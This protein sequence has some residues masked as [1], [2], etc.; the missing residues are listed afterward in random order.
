METDMLKR[1]LCGV[2]DRIERAACRTG[3]RVTL[4]AA[5][6]TVPAETV[7]ALI[8]MGVKDVGENR[9]QEYLKKRDEVTGAHWH[10]IGTLQRNKAK[11]LVGNVVLIQSVSSISLAEE[12]DRLAAERGVIQ[13]V[14]AELNAADEPMKTGAK[15]YEIDEL[16]ERMRE[17]THIRLRGLMA[18]PPIGA[19]DDVYRRVSR[20]YEKYRSGEFDTLS[21]GMSGDYERAIAFGSNMV[22]I[23]TALFGRRI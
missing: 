1:E 4:V 13:A 16:I 11:Y 23:G 21:L 19:D 10:F 15:T 12:I 9:V 5:T 18:V 20:I 2:L 22:R 6:K 8:S 3:A 7:S 14:L 17:F